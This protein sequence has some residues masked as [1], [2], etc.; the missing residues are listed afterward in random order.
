M[1]HPL[2]DR[3]AQGP[4]L[5]DGAMGTLLYARG[6]PLDDC[7]DALNLTRPQL[8]QELHLAY[9]HAGADIVETNTFGANLFKLEAFGLED[10]ARAINLRAVN[11]ARDAERLAGR[12]V[13]I[14][15]A[16]GPTGRTLAPIGTADPADVRAAFR[17]QIGAL[18]ERGV[19]LLILETMPALDEIEEALAAAREAGCDVPIVAQLTFAIDGKT[20]RGHTPADVVARLRPHRDHGV[21]AIGANCSTGPRDVLS[22]A[23]AMLRR[24]DGRGGQAGSPDGVPL[25]VSGQPNAGWPHNHAGRVIYPSS[26]EYFAGFARDLAEAGGRII[27]GCC[28][29]TPDHTRAMRAALDEWRREQALA[30]QREA[31]RTAGEGAPTVTVP[32]APR[33]RRET[34]GRAIQPPEG[35][36]ELATK[37]GR[38]FVVSVELDPPRGLNPAKLL[39]GARMLKELGVDAINVADSPMARVRMDALTICYLLQHTV[40]VET[41]IHFTTRD[42]NLMALQ[43]VLMGAHAAGVRNILALT[44]DPP[45]LGDYPNATAVYDVDSIGLIRILAQLNAG[46]DSAG[47]SIG[48]QASFT[49]AC[50]ADPTRPDLPEETDRLHRKLA[51]GA[52]FVM[53]QIIYDL[54]SW[55]R[56]VALYEQRHGPIEVP[57]LLGVLP[58]QSHKQAEFLHNEVPGIVLPD[59]VRERMRLAGTE[60][61]R[62]GVK[63]A[64]ELLL[65][66]RELAQGCYIMPSFDRYE[67]AAEVLE[68]LR[69]TASEGLKV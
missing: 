15:G 23:R 10:Q 8:V 52:N 28:G 14:A 38:K 48:K 61:R 39:R 13:L 58:L 12:E 59:E 36:T 7:F 11:I 63:M 3:L 62:E 18:L 27:G 50:A 17:E 53:T 69:L 4:L 44:G 46:T 45:N 54:D 21:V 40:G 37:L 2:L 47:N 26:P 19:D 66:V 55:R 9:I 24:L 34:Q 6:V 56:F 31:S 1:P 65:E 29:T 16:V 51:A 5:C 67:L 22:V 64:Q 30:A 43:S 35:P 33:E 20:P 49:I 42:R 57:V 60:G 68:V 41:I 25:Y 32:E